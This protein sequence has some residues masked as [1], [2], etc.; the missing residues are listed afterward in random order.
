MENRTFYFAP[1]EG[2][3][4]YIYRNT[5]HRLFEPMDAYFIPFLT[6]DKN[7]KL[8]RRQRRDVL[9]ENNEGL[10]VIPQI[11]TNK[12]EE[13][14][15]GARQLEELGYREVNLNLGCPS[16]CVVSKGRGAGF[17]GDVEKLKRFLDTIFSGTRMRISIKTRIGVEDPEEFGPLLEV[18]DRYPI[19]ELII[20]PRTAKE[21]YTGT[22]HWEIYRFAREKSSLPLCYNGDL[23]T[24]EEYE[25]WDY[26]FPK[27]RAVMFGR[28]VLG[29]PLL[30]SRIRRTK[31]KTATW[32]DLQYELYVAYQ[33]E[34]GNEQHVLSR[35]KE[36]WTYCA[37]CHPEEREKIRQIYQ[38]ETLQEYA[39][40]LHF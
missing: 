15:N 20:H 26:A 8:S 13:F 12:E 27:S 21:F 11:L 39:K 4:D 6:P 5:Y 23:F 17:L 40:R 38:T 16:R 37:L 1:L 32:E 29:D 18:F 28:G 9:P 10:H 36:F 31:G 33:K 19:S 30:L 3:T 7:G 34:I 25:A 35:L 14:L 2:I 22:V 24:L